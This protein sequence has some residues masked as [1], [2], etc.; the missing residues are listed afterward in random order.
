MRVAE[1]VT[2]VA[3]V[4]AALAT[5]ACCLPLTFLGSASLAAISVWAGPYRIWLIGI[6]LL[7]LVAGFL[8][9]YRRRGQC[10]PGSRLSVALFWISVVIV[11][12]IVFLPQL[13]ANWLAG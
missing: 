12:M 7:F 8:Q 11:L 2:P 10:R 9:L 6:A 1:R 3:A 13:I 4:L 5:V